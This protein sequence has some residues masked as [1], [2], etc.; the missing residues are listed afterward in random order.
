MKKLSFILALILC[1][2]LCATASAIEIPDGAYGVLWIPCLNIR[3]PVYTADVS[4]HEHEQAVIDDE[5]SALLDNWGTA[6]NIC[7][8]AFS[9][10]ENGNEWNIQKIFCGAY[11]WLYTEEAHYFLECY[12]TG[13]TDYQGGS[14]FICGRLVIP[15]SSYD[16]MLSCCAE[17]SHHHFIA[18]FRRLGAY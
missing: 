13:K 4:D 2:S 8:H 9:E 3:M 15:C 10:D 12:M 1:I 5:Q 7:D 14:E 6:Y 18:V 11:A 16:I 17:D